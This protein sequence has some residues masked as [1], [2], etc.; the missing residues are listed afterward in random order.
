MAFFGGMF[1]QGYV[2][3]VN[4]APLYAMGGFLWSVS[5]LLKKY[6][7][8]QADHYKKGAQEKKTTLRDMSSSLLS[9]LVGSHMIPQDQAKV[10]EEG[11]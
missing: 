11:L 8:T 4:S 6:G 10:L 3:E 7:D 9:L 5:T 1:V 2:S